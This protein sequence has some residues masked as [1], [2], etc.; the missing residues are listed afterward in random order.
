MKYFEIVIEILDKYSVL[1]ET[2]KNLD[3]EN[4]EEIIEEALYQELIDDNEA[5][6]ICFISEVDKG[7]DGFIYKKT[8]IL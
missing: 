4:Y 7:K 1:L 6:N 2:D 5:E 3:I 8:K